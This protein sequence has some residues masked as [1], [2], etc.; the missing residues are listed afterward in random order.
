MSKEKK[1]LI[2]AVIIAVVIIFVATQV[3][4]QSADVVALNKQVIAPTVQVSIEDGDGKAEGSGTVIFSDKLQKDPDHVRT[5]ILTNF[6]VIAN[7]VEKIDSAPGFK[8]T[9]EIKVRSF[10]YVDTSEY[11]SASE[12]NAMVYGID[13][14]HDLALLMLMETA[15]KLPSARIMPPTGRLDQGE[16]V[17]ACGAGLGNV[18][19]VSPPGRV[20]FN[21]VWM[22]GAYYTLVTT[23][24][25]FGNS[26]GG[27][28]RRAADGVWEFVGVPSDVSGSPEGAVWHVSFIVPMPIIYS[29]LDQARM[30][31][32]GDP[33]AYKMLVL[34]DKPALPPGPPLKK[35]AE[36]K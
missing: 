17:I 10:N 9:K 29:F 35:K 6:H 26:G 3:H 15:Q 1:A 2:W 24:I 30:A 4:A 16:E 11:V 18:P 12:M 7:A 5:V 36:A 32:V 23:P 22:R 33:D 20:G 21:Q 14:D 13:K 25:T 8:Q 27:L 19:Y 34:G 31:W 28:Y